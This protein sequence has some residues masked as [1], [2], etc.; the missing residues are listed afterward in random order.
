[1]VPGFITLGIAG[2]VIPE[3]GATRLLLRAA[4]VGSARRGV[5]MQRRT[6]SRPSP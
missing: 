5:P 4:G 6:L 2:L 1:M 3:T